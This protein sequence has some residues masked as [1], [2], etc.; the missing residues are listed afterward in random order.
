MAPMLICVAVTPGAADED[1]A[2]LVDVVAVPVVAVELDAPP[3]DDDDE[4]PAAID[5]TP[6]ATATGNTPLPRCAPM[7]TLSSIRTCRIGSPPK[8]PPTNGRSLSLFL[9]HAD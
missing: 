9:R 8:R 6:S 1:V 7:S 4:H 3:P 2:P 5:A